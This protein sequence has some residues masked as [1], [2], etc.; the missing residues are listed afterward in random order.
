MSV[1]PLTDEE[2]M[3]F[4]SEARGTTCRGGR[5]RAPSEVNR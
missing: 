1:E 5:R 4:V 2:R 3:V